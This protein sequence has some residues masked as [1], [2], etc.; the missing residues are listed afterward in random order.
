MFNS[1]GYVQNK[2]KAG[3]VVVMKCIV[4]IKSVVYAI[5]E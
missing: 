2:A 1:K 4:S 3:Y 5:P